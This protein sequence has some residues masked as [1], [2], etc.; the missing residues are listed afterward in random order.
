M[1]IS[2][3]VIFFAVSQSKVIFTHSEADSVQTKS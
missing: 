2:V 3:M 1:I